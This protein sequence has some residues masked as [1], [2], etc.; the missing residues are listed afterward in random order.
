MTPEQFTYW[1]QG[2]AEL[3]EGT[4]PTPEQWKSINDHLKTVFVKVTPPVS[5]D[6]LRDSQTA[7]RTQSYED[8]I[9]Q[10]LGSPGVDTSRI[11]C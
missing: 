2:F 5:F 11:T 4:P 10:L 3:N 1:L 7:R 6:Q 8:R 9:S